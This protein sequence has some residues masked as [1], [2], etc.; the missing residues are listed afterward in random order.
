MSSRSR[1]NQQIGEAVSLESAWPPDWMTTYS[2]MATL[3]MTFFI[4]LS[5]MLALKIDIRYLGER[6][7]ESTEELAPVETSVLAELTPEDQNL[8][9]TF[10]NLDEQQLRELARI[11]RIEQLG[12][13]IQQ[14]ILEAKLS[15]FI[16]VDISKWKIT[17][18]PLTPFLFPPGRTTLRP[19]A[20][21]FLDRIADFIKLNPCHVRVL[22]HTDNLPI[23]NRRFSSNWEL[24]VS[25][26]AAIMRYLMEK[27]A[28]PPQKLS[29]IGYGPHRPVASNDTPEGRA[30]NRRVEIEITQKTGTDSESEY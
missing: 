15:G 1:A 27:H 26:A 14:Y 24:S 29:A 11:T 9:K 10:R 6:Y 20:R 3:L 13:D 16:K 22:G 12:K 18:V 30:K 7:V 5:T 8:I 21:E 19:T 28:I 23:H 4:I 17:I 2:D 25:R